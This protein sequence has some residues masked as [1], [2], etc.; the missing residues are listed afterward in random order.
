[1]A[2][3]YSRLEMMVV[4]ASRLLCNGERVLVGTGIPL[5]AAILAKK[6]HAADMV[7]V[8]EAVAF[9]SN[10]EAL[11]FCVADPRAVYRTTWTPTSA[12]V[13][14]HFLQ[15]GKIDVGFLGGAQVDRY[16]NLNST[17]IGP[18]HRPE[19]RFEGSG[20]ASD[21]ASLAKRTII[22][23]NHER[24]RFV[25]QVD[26]ITSPGWKCRSLDGKSDA[27]RADAGLDG[28]PYAVVS[29][30]GVM[31]FDE[32]SRE[33]YVDTY[34]DDLGVSIGDIA[35][36]TEFEIDVSRGRPMAPPTPEEL[37]VLREKVDPEGIF[38]RY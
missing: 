19:K 29:T 2:P 30:L 21:I 17:C 4:A 6:T 26:Y 16:G 36:M 27:M 13:M 15:S 25:D 9:D 28:G 20:G 33:M 11:P 37:T 32:K 35:R 3:N 38:M 22:I 10:P 24:R 8:M 1:M 14:G 18:Y 5:V 7:M 34:Y 31:A 12:E 23:M